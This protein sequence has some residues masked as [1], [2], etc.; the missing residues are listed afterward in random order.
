MQR[1]SVD[2]ILQVSDAV[3]R[4]RTSNLTRFVVIGRLEF[5]IDRLQ[6]CMI[7]LVGASGLQSGESIFETARMNNLKLCFPEGVFKQ[8]RSKADV[9]YTLSL[10]IEKSCIDI[11]EFG[12]LF[13]D[14]SRCFCGFVTSLQTLLP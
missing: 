5:G 2:A 14:S 10:L 12:E 7:L 9:P 6:F 13:D 4:N 11:F 8:S 3:F 1:D